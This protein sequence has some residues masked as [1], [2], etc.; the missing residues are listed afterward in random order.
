MA[1]TF[2]DCILERGTAAVTEEAARVV[3]SA[4][5]GSPGRRVLAILRDIDTGLEANVP[6]EGP[7][8]PWQQMRVST[9]ADRWLSETREGMAVMRWD[10]EVV[11]SAMVDGAKKVGGGVDLV[12]DALDALYGG[13]Q[14][15]LRA[16]D[17]I[18]EL[19]PAQV[20][21]DWKGWVQREPASGVPVADRL[22]PRWL[23]GEEGVWRREQ[24]ARLDTWLP[25]A[26][27][28][29]W[30]TGYCDGWADARALAALDDPAEAVSTRPG[31]VHGNRVVG[32]EV[33]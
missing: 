2:S 15:G 1:T 27:A 9:L 8:T 14:E 20:V 13:Y 3:L 19:D 12:G 16:G 23:T 32:K 18:V 5:L 25:G 33:S 28:R 4:G 7:L 22:D 29:A 10:A 17:V 26:L 24:V 11:E 6:G 31:S 30:V 21:N